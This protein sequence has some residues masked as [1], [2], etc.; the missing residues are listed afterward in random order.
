M[1]ILLFL[2]LHN[3]ILSISWFLGRS[4]MTIFR[5]LK[6]LILH[7]GEEMQPVKMSGDVECDELYVTAGLKGRNNS[8]CIKRLGREPRCRGLKRRG[9]GTWGED[10]PPIFILVER[11]GGE[12]YVP[13][14]DVSGGTVE[15]VVGR[16][17]SKDST[18]YTDAFTSYSVLDELG[19]RH[20][21]VNHSA[22]EYVRGEAHVNGCENRGSY[23]PDV[24]CVS[25][26]CV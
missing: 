10:K 13:S 23:S 1:L 17:V 14:S 2:A 11:G 20:V 7:I 5:A 18:V 21:G 8:T 24:V 3:S 9:R 22:G 12:D 26:R 15:K 16:R 25:Q 6:K 4:Y 19:Y